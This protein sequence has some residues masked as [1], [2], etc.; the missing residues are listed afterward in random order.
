MKERSVKDETAENNTTRD[1]VKKAVFAI[2]RALGILIFFGGALLV[3]Y[4]MASFGMFPAYVIRVLPFIEIGL[5]VAVILWFAGC[6]PKRLT[7]IAWGL[8]GCICLVSAIY[9]GR[10]WYNS[11]IPTVDDRSLLLRDYIPYAKVNQLVELEEEA[12]LKLTASERLEL[13]G[14][15]ALYPI[16]AAFVQATYPASVTD[17]GY[18]PYDSMVQCSGTTWAYERLIRGE[19][20]MIFVGAPSEEQLKIAERAGVEL[21]FTPIGREAFVFFVNSKNPVTGL[22]VEQIQGIYSGE[23]T[24]WSEVGGK[25]QRIRPFQRD[26]NSGS[27]SAL[28]RLMAGL[29]LIE[30][31]E[32]DRIEGMGGIIRSVANY[33]NHENALGFSFRYYSTQMVK[34]NEIRL[35]AINGVEPN[36]DTIRDGSYPIASEFFAVTASPIGEPA[37]EEG[38]IT[39][40]NFLDWILSEQGKYIVEETGYVAVR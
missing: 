30:P 38:N 10:S 21:H 22:T 28:E 31:E 26:Q 17:E 23:I 29:E 18:H 14:A 40:K 25:W 20:D 12:E 16:Y 2:C 13:D 8:F 24:N 36:K 15:T 34:N 39:I 5:L 19:V 37:P 11:T 35:L 32:E 6:V 1:K 7:R 4:I 33:R 3:F 27:Q 9:I